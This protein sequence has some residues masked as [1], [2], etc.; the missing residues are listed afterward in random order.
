MAKFTGTI[1]FSDLEGGFFQLEADDGTTYR[2]EG[3]LSVK[4]GERVRIDGTVAAGGF[5]I[6]MSG[7]ALTVRSVEPA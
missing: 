4:A 3:D 5:G 2:L 6:H 1:R 7:P